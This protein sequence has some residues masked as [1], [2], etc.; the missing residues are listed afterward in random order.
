MNQDG[1]QSLKEP[2]FSLTT[3]SLLGNMV[4]RHNS[5]MYTLGVCYTYNLQGYVINTAKLAPLIEAFVE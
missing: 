2:R 4:L 5:L 3:L 1:R